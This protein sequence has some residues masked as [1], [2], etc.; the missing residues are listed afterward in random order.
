M[1]GVNEELS[2]A[3]EMHLDGLDVVLEGLFALLLISQS[4]S[5]VL[6]TVL[7]RIV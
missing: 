5:T 6:H 7:D 3:R 1:E 2:S 4:Y